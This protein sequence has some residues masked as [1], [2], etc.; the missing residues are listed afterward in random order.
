[1][2]QQARTTANGANATDASPNFR[3]CDLE[4]A[5]PISVS[6]KWVA[7]ACRKA[8]AARPRWNPVSST[9]TTTAKRANGTSETIS[10]A[11]GKSDRSVR[12]Q[13]EWA[14][15]EHATDDAPAARRLVTELVTVLQWAVKTRAS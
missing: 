14:A 4:V 9:W 7:F 3:S 8:G 13:A 10:I 6:H 1:M 2:Q 5:T 12:V 11:Q 15:S